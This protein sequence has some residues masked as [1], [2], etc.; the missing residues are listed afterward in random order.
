[1]AAKSRRAGRQRRQARREAIKQPRILNNK[2]NLIEKYCQTKDAMM[3]N[4]PAD[5]MQK[6]C[7]KITTASRYSCK[8]FALTRNK[9]VT[10]ANLQQLDDKVMQNCLHDLRS[11]VSRL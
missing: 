2:K 3:P 11:I 10:G 5:T 6:I 4:C 7:I 8:Y 9:L 1:V